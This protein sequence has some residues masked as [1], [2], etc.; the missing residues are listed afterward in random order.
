MPQSP[1][2][3]ASPQLLHPANQHDEHRTQQHRDHSDREQRR[4][5][6]SGK[7][8]RTDN[9]RRK[10]LTNGVGKIQNAQILTSFFLTWQHIDVQRLIDGNVNAITGTADACKQHHAQSIR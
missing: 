9:H 8:N 5:T 6:A 10:H 2:H 1:A 7:H 3:C 4:I